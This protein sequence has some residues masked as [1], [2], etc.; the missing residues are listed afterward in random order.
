MRMNDGFVIPYLR[1]CAFP[2]KTATFPL[3]LLSEPCNNYPVQRD[4]FGGAVRLAEVRLQ[5]GES[6]ENALRRFKR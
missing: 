6:L 5:E 3:D 4:E 1:K 2:A